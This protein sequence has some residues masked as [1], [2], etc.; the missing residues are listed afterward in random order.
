M[1][2]SYEE[3]YFELGQ[4]DRFVSVHFHEGSE[5]HGLLG[6]NEI[7]GTFKFIDAEIN[8]L[9]KLRGSN[10]L[11]RTEAKV[12]FFPASPENFSE[13]VLTTMDRDGFLCSDIHV[14]YK[15]DNP[16]ENRYIKKGVKEIPNT[17]TV[18][19]DPTGMDIHYANL[20]LFGKWIERGCTFPDF[21]WYRYYALLLYYEPETTKEKEVLYSNFEKKELKAEIRCEFLK[22]KMEK[23]ELSDQEYEELYQLLK[24]FY[25]KRHEIAMAELQRS[26]NNLKELYRDYPAKVRSIPS[27]VVNFEDDVLVYGTPSIWWDLER[28]L[29]IYQRHVRE[30][31]MG[32]NFV[33]KG[34]FQYKFK[35]VKRVIKYVIESVYD[36]IVEHFKT[37]P[38][39]IYVRMG[40]RA[41]NYDGNFYRIDIEPSGRLLTCHPYRTLVEAE[42]DKVED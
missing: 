30:V 35:D 13:A 41:I 10:A 12:K 38:D 22:V 11:P 15:R 7:M 14:I 28:H 32:V 21:K 16:K 1:I 40:S 27:A 6:T 9:E 34:V 36:E 33:S 2:Y 5:T 31:Q 39:K 42:E 18:K 4:V 24:P 8:A 23:N 20:K 25:E 29:H 26:S 3:V 17:I 37:S 19:F